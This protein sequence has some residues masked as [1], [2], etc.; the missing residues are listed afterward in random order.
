VWLQRLLAVVAI[1][2]TVLAVRW[3]VKGAG[4]L[5]PGSTERHGADVE[6]F[7]IS[8]REVGRKLPVSVVVPDG[9]TGRTPLLVF[10]HGR[11]GDEDSSL[12]EPMFEALD[13]LGSRAPMIAFPYGGDHS[14]WH[15]RDDGDWEGYVVDEVVPQVA[16]RF[17]A[18]P[19]RVAIGGISM[20]GFGAYDIARL[21]PNRFC[22]VGGHAPTLWASA[23][24][25]ADGAFDDAA[26]FAEH[27]VVGAGATGVFNRQPVWLDAGIDDPFLPGGDAF[28][29]GLK[30]AGANV[31]ER[32]GPGG[33]DASY[34]DRRW[35]D[36][37]RFY[38]R[39]LA[40]C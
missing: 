11:E 33:H 25:V 20:G 10:L 34:W 35:D 21:N 19:D 36:Y 8:S 6:N 5:L 12:V 27:D 32:H 4:T 40:R 24:E 31:T 26:D 28:V 37:L 18:D 23:A 15:D 3:I 38:A 2:A 9:A 29:A 39:A 14:Y 17:S 30:S 1:A 7:A 22:A 13:E 16:R